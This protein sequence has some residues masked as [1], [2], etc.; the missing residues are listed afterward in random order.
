MVLYQSQ[1]YLQWIVDQSRIFSVNRAACEGTSGCLVN[2]DRIVGTP[3]DSMVSFF[4]HPC[5]EVCIDHNLQTLR[6][7]RRDA[8]FAF[9]RV[10]GVNPSDPRQNF[11][12]VSHTS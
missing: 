3:S 4:G 7:G 5:T 9:R 8:Q 12:I 11:F 2:Y 10:T 6:L 1:T